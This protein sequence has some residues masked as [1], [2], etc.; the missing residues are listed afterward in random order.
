MIYSISLSCLARVF[1]TMLKQRD[2]KETW[3]RKGF[4]LLM[5]AYHSSSLKAIS[6]GLKQSRS[7]KA[8][9][10]MED[11]EDAY[12]LVHPGFLYLSGKQAQGWHHSHCAEIFY[13]KHQ[14]AYLQSDFM[15]ELISSDLG[16]RH[17]YWWSHL[18]DTFIFLLP[19]T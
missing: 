13:F 7:L 14:Q 12:Y 1:I 4:I 9:A 19:T 16:N 3:G 10:Y 5:L 8:A 2:L 17:L 15:I 6:K 18:N 11:M